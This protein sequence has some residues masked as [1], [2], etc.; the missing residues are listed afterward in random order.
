M[1]RYHRN[2]IAVGTVRSRCSRACSHNMGVTG[3]YERKSAQTRRSAVGLVGVSNSRMTTNCGRIF[4]ATR[5]RGEQS[6][7]GLEVR[8]PWKSKL[9]GGILWSAAKK[10]CCGGSSLSVERK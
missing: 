6:L 1:V 10:A 8:G 7:L 4:S 9:D 3:V 5:V 2:V